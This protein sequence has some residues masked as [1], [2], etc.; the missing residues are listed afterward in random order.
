MYA[1]RGW[2]RGLQAALVDV[3]SSSLPWATSS[4]NVAQ[5]RSAPESSVSYQLPYKHFT[6]PS[7]TQVRDGPFQFIFTRSGLRIVVDKTPP[8]LVHKC[9]A[10]AIPRYRDSE[11]VF[12]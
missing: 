12:W 3:V 10:F 1:Y 5:L 4:L 7:S 6:L 8:S 2:K 9:G 11:K